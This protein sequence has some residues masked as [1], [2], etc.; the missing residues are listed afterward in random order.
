MLEITTATKCLLLRIFYFSKE[1]MKSI[2]AYGYF[3]IA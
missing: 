2:L 3:M 1:L